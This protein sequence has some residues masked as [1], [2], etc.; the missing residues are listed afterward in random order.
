[1]TLR[2]IKIFV[3]VCECGSVTAAADKLF[4]AQPAASL[5]I[6]ELE[7]YYG[8]KLFDRISK[9]LHITET[10]KQFLQYATHIVSL[11]DV[12]EKEIK[13]WDN[14]GILRV[15]TSI[16]IGNYLLPNYVGEFQRRFPD[17]QIKAIIDNTESIVERVLKNEV[18]FGLIEG[19]P[20]SSFLISENFMDDKL[21]AICAKNHKWADK[22][23]ISINQ[24]KD[25]KFILR[26]KGSAGREIFE[27]ILRIHGISAEPIWESV[28]S[29]AIIRAV[30]KGIG[31]SVLPY[32]LVKESLERGEIKS[33]A[34]KDIS[35]ER[36]FSVIY[37]KNKF[38][39]E[40][41]NEFIKMCFSKE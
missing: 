22:D 24:L 41:A 11:F 14:I 30:S 40:S 35:L 7:D 28:S 9:R 31:V 27:S 15:G 37:H 17:I 25:E 18:D 26:E 5:A 8:V 4:I 34:I 20:N 38:L 23:T 39:T 13:N 10:G 6:S 1:M 12:M 21:V 19:N 33:V 36:K 29:Q 2:H 32:L 3:A 16:T